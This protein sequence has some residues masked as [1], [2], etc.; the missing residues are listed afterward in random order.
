[1]LGALALLVGSAG[2]AAG[3]GPTRTAPAADRGDHPEEIRIGVLAPTSG[4]DAKTGLDAVR[5]SQL[6][7][8][9]INSANPAVALPLAAGTGLPHVGNAT[10]TIVPTDTA[11]QPDQAMVMVRQLYDDHVTGV[12]S[13][14]GPEVSASAS[15]GAERLRLPF[16]EAY[17]AADYLTERGLEWF[18]RTAPTYRTL[19]ATTLAWLTS[20]L[21]GKAV[22]VLHSDDRTGYSVRTEVLRLAQE[23]GAGAQVAAV[24]PT[25]GDGRAA[26]RTVRT[27]SPEVVFLGA[28]TPAQAQALLKGV[29]DAG[30]NPPALVAMGPGFDTEDG[31]RTNGMYITAA[32]VPQLAGLNT[33]VQAVT[34]R[35]QRRYGTPMSETAAATFT[36]V[37]AL[38]Q[39]VDRAAERAEQ[40]SPEAIR[41]AMLGLDMPDQEMIG[42]ANGVLFDLAHQN[43]RAIG[44]IA[45]YNGDRFQLVYPK[46]PSLATENGSSAG[47]AAPPRADRANRTP[48]RNR[49]ATTPPTSAGR[50]SR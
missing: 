45:R 40:L 43:S 37:L 20:R 25:D 8:E 3:T 11:D 12:V 19:S 33:S 47:R 22:G 9:F 28:Q 26:A 5:G 29:D 46:D 39:A 38:A 24:L 36:A 1:M 50:G 16:V 17:C 6:A 14:S 13:A 44:V 49:P 31:P 15:Q 34:D 4:T 18:F 32:W 27:A 23:A 2:C 42:P 7:A 30:L 21:D 10:V 41:M 35:Y 48:Q